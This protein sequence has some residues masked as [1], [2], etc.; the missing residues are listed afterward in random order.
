MNI[1]CYDFSAPILDHNNIAMQ[2]PS[3]R[4]G[5]AEIATFSH[6]ALSALSNAYEGETITYEAKAYRIDLAKRIRGC[7]TA[8]NLTFIDRVL[9]TEL[10]NRITQSPIIFQRF[11]EFLESSHIPAL[12]SPAPEPVADNVVALSP[13]ADIATT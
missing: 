12:V 6:F 9:L 11:I 5:A 13:D 10:L 2:I 4:T 1:Y 7:V 3:P 8:V